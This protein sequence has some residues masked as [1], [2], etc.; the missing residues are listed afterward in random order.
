VLAICVGLAQE[1]AAVQ[2]S[3]FQDHIVRGT[4]STSSDR[5]AEDAGFVARV[6]AHVLPTEPIKVL[7]RRGDRI[8]L[9]GTTAAGHQRKKYED[10]SK[11][12]D[13]G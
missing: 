2:P 1:Y 12:G 5:T 8:V 13:D 11:L 7:G 6:A 10:K 9:L 4:D 3:F